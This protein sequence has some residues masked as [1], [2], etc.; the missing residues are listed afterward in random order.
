MNSSILGSISTVLVFIAFAGVCWWAYSPS[1]KKQFEEA[2]KL[3]FADDARNHDSESNT[4]F[5]RA[6]D[7]T[8]QDK[9]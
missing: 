2:A 6:D 1:R 5:H 8:G 7:E 3:P 4:E 9:I